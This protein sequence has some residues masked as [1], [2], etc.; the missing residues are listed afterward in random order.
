MTNTTKKDFTRWTDDPKDYPKFVE[1]DVIPMLRKKLKEG[2]HLDMREILS[3][4]IDPE[5]NN[6]ELIQFLVDSEVMSKAEFTKLVKR[7]EWE[8]MVENELGF[9]PKANDHE[10]YVT[11]YAKHKG[12]TVKVNGDLVYNQEMVCI[13]GVEISE[14][15]LQIGPGASENEK[16]EARRMLAMIQAARAVG[17]NIQN[18][19]NELVLTA[20]RLVLKMDRKLIQTAASEWFEQQTKL[21]KIRMVD[22]LA[23]DEDVVTTAQ[24]DWD[25][26]ERGPFIEHSDGRAFNSLVLKKF[27][28]QV[29]RKLRGSTVTNHLMPVITGTQGGGK[30]EFVKSFLS[31]INDLWASVDFHMVTDN[32]NIDL[33]NNAAL[34]FDEMSY[35]GSVDVNAVKGLITMEKLPRRPMG[36][37]R[38][39]DIRQSATFIGCSN[40]SLAEL[41]N[42]STGMRRYAEL[43]FRPKAEQKWERTN[44]I[45]WLN[46]WRSVD[47]T[48]DD[49]SVG[50]FDLMAEQQESV[51]R[52]D[53]VEE[54][55]HTVSPSELKDK[56]T[57]EECFAMYSHW[58]SKMYPSYKINWGQFKPKFKS[59]IES[60]HFADMGWMRKEHSKKVYVLI[61]SLAA[62]AGSVAVGAC[63]SDRNSDVVAVGQSKPK[64]NLLKLAAN[65]AAR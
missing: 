62:G 14:S 27:I 60:K 58:M 19:E 20:G 47:E 52:M 63:E 61:E 12:I 3:L 59:L 40:K 44:S 26:I 7:M 23:F 10:H 29:K 35:A 2:D 41:F 11:E 38:T 43:E 25:Y 39:V 49:P 4:Y 32:R 16:K 56:T 51:R 31:P 5:L 65:R 42:D 48:A 17:K 37:N 34:F 13:D 9:L 54:W 64:T 30:S 6:T 21:A 8:F 22:S 50:I 18:F 24:A 36:T 46:L 57:V 1:D 55:M 28:W 53:P 45:N 15:D 33:W